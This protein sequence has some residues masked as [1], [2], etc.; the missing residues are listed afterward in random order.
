[1]IGEL[2][3]RVVSFTVGPTGLLG[4]EAFDRGVG[5]NEPVLLVVRGAELFEENALQGWGGGFI[6]RVSR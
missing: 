3:D 5:V 1:M 4:G 2:A 6:F